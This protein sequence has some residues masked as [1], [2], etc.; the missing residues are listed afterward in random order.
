MPVHAGY[1]D[2]P[3]AKQAALGA[4]WGQGMK[5]ELPLVTLV[6]SAIDGLRAMRVS[7][8]FCCLYA[9]CG[10]HGCF[11]DGLLKH[12]L[13]VLLPLMLW[14]AASGGLHHDC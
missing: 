3:A 9:S 14:A 13:Y 10:R 4:A 8:S 1:F 6:F 12:G 5:A 7:P 11:A 2:A